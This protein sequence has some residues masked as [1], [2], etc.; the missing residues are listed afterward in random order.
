VSISVKFGAADC[1]DD[2]TLTSI[3]NAIRSLTQPVNVTLLGS[4]N[5]LAA[6]DRGECATFLGSRFAQNR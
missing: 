6:G 3:G 4:S 2:K 5:V 1:V